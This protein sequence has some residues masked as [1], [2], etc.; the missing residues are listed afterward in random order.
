MEGT[1]IYKADIES[2]PQFI[3]AS[4]TNDSPGWIR[5]LAQEVCPAQPTML[6]VCWDGG[7]V[8]QKD[9]SE[10]TWQKFS[11]QHNY[12]T[13]YLQAP[14]GLKGKM[15]WSHHGPATVIGDNPQKTTAHVVS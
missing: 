4:E 6:S 7:I 13:V 8:Y 10:N 14:H 1:E 12:P 9:F 3:V 11:R 5:A 2:A 15:V